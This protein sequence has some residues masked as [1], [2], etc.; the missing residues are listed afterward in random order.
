MASVPLAAVDFDYSVRVFGDGDVVDLN[1]RDWGAVRMG[2]CLASLADVRGRVLEIGCGAGRCIRT[3]HRHRPDLEAFGCDLSARSIEAAR[4]YG[5]GIAYETADATALP[6]PDRSFDAVVIMDLIEHLP[7]VDRALAEVHRV[8]KPGARLHVH[9]PCEGHLLSVYKPLLAL[10]IDLTRRAVG[11]VH[12]FTRKDVRAHLE[13]AGFEVT[14]RRYSMYLFGQLH[15]L[16]SW[17][18][19]LRQGHNGPTGA[20]T[21]SS[22]APGLMTQPMAAR[23]R[24]K[25]IYTRPAWWV[26]KTLLPWLQ[27]GELAVVGW[28][29]LG[30]VGL[31]VT[32]TRRR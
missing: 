25:H 14:R 1:R 28:Q 20:K 13:R 30:S 12:H 9:V 32:A 7:D 4:R 21:Q 19:T 17:W 16:I 23:F 6:Y 8:C 10:G 27:Y 11:H 26:V 22:A 29:P 3:I 18:S 2:R 5:G 31:C 15:D 24:L